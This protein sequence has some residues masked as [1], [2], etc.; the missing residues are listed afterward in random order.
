MVSNQ[1]PRPVLAAPE[2]IYRRRGTVGTVIAQKVLYASDPADIAIDMHT[3]IGHDE[4][5]MLRPTQD[6]VPRSKYLTC[7]VEHRPTRMRARHI[8]GI[9][10]NC[11]H[12]LG[13]SLLER[14]VK[15][16]VGGQQFGKLR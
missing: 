13:R 16:T 5:Q 4:L 6:A 14:S 12:G 10:P 11:G 1:T 3:L 2:H 9:A 8:V 15:R 7:A